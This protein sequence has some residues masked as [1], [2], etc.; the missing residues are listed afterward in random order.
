MR[1]TALIPAQARLILSVMAAVGLS[2]LAAWSI[3][4]GPE[5]LSDG[6][7]RASES[8][9]TTSSPELAVDLI[10]QDA[11]AEQEHGGDDGYHT[12]LTPC[13][14][15]RIAELV[16]WVLLDSRFAAYLGP[17]SVASNGSYSMSEFSARRT[18]RDRDV[19]RP[20]R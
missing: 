3:F 7:C 18:K 11:R 1:L 9:A 2:L 6:R 15:L 20:A 8:V 16:N 12:T 13:H 10:A 14:G 5:W 4:G 19:G 17:R